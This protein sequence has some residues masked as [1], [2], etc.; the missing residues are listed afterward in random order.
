MWSG[1]GGVIRIKNHTV[2]HWAF[3]CGMGSDSRDE[4]LGVWA[5]LSIASRLHILDLQVLGD[6]KIIID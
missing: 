3:N 6:S 1:G 5:L 4:I 2:F